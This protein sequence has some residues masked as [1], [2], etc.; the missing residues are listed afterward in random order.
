M[1]ILGVVKG[2]RV[3]GGLGRLLLVARFSWVD[4]L[5][6]T[7]FAKVWKTDL[8]FSHGLSSGD[9]VFGLTGGTLLLD[10]SHICGLYELAEEQ[11]RVSMSRS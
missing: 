2:S 5:P 1:N 3:T 4:S 9:E 11:L 8:E 7:E 6:D 10:S